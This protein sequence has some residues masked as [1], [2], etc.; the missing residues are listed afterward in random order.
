M[1]LQMATDENK[2]LREELQRAGECVEA[3]VVSGNSM[4]AEIERL[5][6]KV[7]MWE[8]YNHLDHKKLATDPDYYDC[9]MMEHFG[10][11]HGFF[12]TEEPFVPPPGYN[13][14]PMTNT[15][16]P[17]ASTFMRMFP[18]PGEEDDSDEV[19]GCEECG[20]Y[21][22]GD[23]EGCDSCGLFMEEPIILL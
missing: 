21:E 6:W 19:V 7:K 17:F 4:K 11:R 9:V 16:P 13:G 20:A 18:P 10:H 2:T 15:F 3:L 8:E 5:E 12:P 14:P 22:G 1:A 23:A